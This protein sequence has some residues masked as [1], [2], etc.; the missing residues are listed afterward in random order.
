[1]FSIERPQMLRPRRAGVPSMCGNDIANSWTL[2]QPRAVPAST[3]WERCYRSPRNWPWKGNTASTGPRLSVQTPWP[4]VGRK[5]VLWPLWQGNHVEKTHRSSCWSSPS[6][7]CLPSM[8]ARRA[9]E[10]ALEDPSLQP[11]SGS[12]RCHVDRDKISPLSS[13]QT[14]DLWAK[15]MQLF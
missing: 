4:W 10:G 2:F 9:S 8:E 11:A 1:M 12:K 14:A 6:C 5:E 13:A 7:L 3:E 15:Q